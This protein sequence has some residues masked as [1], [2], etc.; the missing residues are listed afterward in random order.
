MAKKTNRF[1]FAGCVAQW[2]ISTAL[3]L[4]SDGKLVGATHISL[5]GGSNSGVQWQVPMATTY[6]V[7]VQIPATASATNAK[8]R[9]YPKGNSPGNPQ[10]SSP[11]PTAWPPCFEVTI[12]QAANKG[13]WL[14]LAKKMDAKTLSEWPFFKEGYVSVNARNV[15]PQQQLGVAAI[16]FEDRMEPIS[17]GKPYAGGIVFYIDGTG[18]HGLVAA[19][20]DQSTGLQ[21]YNDGFYS[22]TN[23]NATSVGAGKTNTATI[24]KNQGVGFYAAT[25]CDR[26]VLEGYGDW[27]LPSKGELAL[28]YKNIGRGAKLPLAN[29]GKFV[30][31]IYW[32]SSEYDTETAWYQNFADGSQGKYD[33]YGG[34]YVRAVRAF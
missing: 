8:Y 15:S 9:L 17:I 34:F 19:P 14:L 3:A 2:A 7:W 11:G 21:W 33:K 30:D 22:N 27:Y 24:I 18:K 20:K 32:S 12:N 1:V 26:L 10:C 5:Q 6:K 28:M 29:I 16:S 13:K 23:A 31:R 25:A 4:P